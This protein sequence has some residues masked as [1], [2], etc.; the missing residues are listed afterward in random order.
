MFPDDTDEDSE[1]EE[2]Q[3]LL[4]T[5]A[6]IHLLQ[7]ATFFVWYIMGVKRKEVDY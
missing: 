7:D 1:H 3:L 5:D 6:K 4:E 2:L